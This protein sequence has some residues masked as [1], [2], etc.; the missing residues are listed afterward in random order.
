M[1]TEDIDPKFADLDIWPTGR[2]VRTMLDSHR[3]AAAAVELQADAIARAAEAAAARLSGPAGRLIYAGAGTSGRIAVLDGVELGPTFG[4]PAAR[5]AWL[6]AGGTGALAAS[7]E[8]AEDDAA[9]AEEAMHAL[10]PGSADVVIGVAASGRTPFTLA[11]I[12]VARSGGALTI[13]MANNPN[14]PL[15]KASEHSILLDTG[16]EAIAGSTRMKAGTA[17]KIALNLLSTAI[18]LRLG[19]VYKG[20]MVDM[21]V[22]NAKLRGRAIAMIGEIAGVGSAEAEAGLDT[23]EGAIKPA[24]LIARG[25]TPEQAAELLAD[26]SGN[27]RLALER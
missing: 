20:L 12:A 25:K 17:Q 18:M 3:D 23:A 8:G 16:A 7:V 24:V 9:A 10:M 15:L 21:R 14:S 13:G 27:L 5:L 2:A 4:W 11:A 26:A 6:I 1:P 19:R 22:S